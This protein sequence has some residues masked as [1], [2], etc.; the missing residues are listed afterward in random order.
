MDKF[1]LFWWELAPYM[2]AENNDTEL[3]GFVYSI[4]LDSI[5]K[6]L[7]WNNSSHG[8]ALQN[9]NLL[10]ASGQGELLESV[11]DASEF[12]GMPIILETTALRDAPASFVR[13]LSTIGKQII[14]L[15][16]VTH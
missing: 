1:N 15:L 6:C 4:F 14:K 13:V 3:S 11:V 2:H 16:C 8:E 7:A 5:T 9:F 10:R 12:A